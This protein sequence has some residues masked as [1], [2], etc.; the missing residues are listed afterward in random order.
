MGQ[1]NNLR[2]VTCS[3]LSD[4][5]ALLTACKWLCVEVIHAQA[6]QKVLKPP[7]PH[8]CHDGGVQQGAMALRRWPVLAVGNRCY[9]AAAV[10]FGAVIS[11]SS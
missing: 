6:H 5:S 3:H 7:E 4:A 9:I 1:P 10:A 8:C 2:H 11:S